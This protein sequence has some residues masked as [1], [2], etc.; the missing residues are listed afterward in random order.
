MKRKL[1][2]EDV[3]KDIEFELAQGVPPKDNLGESIEAVRQFQNKLRAELDI[4]NTG[5]PSRQSVGRL[6][7]LNDMLVTL[8]QE[9]AGVIAQLQ[10]TQQLQIRHAHASTRVL[11]DQ[12]DP[13]AIRITEH[14]AKIDEV[15]K[16]KSLFVAKDAQRSTIP[17]IGRWISKLRQAL[18]SL[19]LYYVRILA[20][21]QTVVNQAF[22]EEY[23]YTLNEIIELRQRVNDLELKITH[24]ESTD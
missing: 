3:I 5:S 9:T 4:S 7:Q 24:P 2:A 20:S 14:I 8:L 17:I 22:S 23:G 12:I 16:S 18:H 11:L 1:S 6:L 19:P 15:A 21:K 13:D 10:L